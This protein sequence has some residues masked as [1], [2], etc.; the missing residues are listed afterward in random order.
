MEV[1]E[2]CVV[3]G[4]AGQVAFLGPKP[5]KCPISSPLSPPQPPSAPSAPSGEDLVDMPAGPW[6]GIVLDLPQGSAPKPHA[7]C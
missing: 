2:R 3:D 6:V 4:R 1:G 7:L 5:P